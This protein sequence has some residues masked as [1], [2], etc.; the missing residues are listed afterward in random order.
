MKSSGPKP[1]RRQFLGGV[2]AGGVTLGLSGSAKAKAAA[3]A[4]PAQPRSVLP[5]PNLIAENETP[6]EE[7]KLTFG[8]A[9]SDFMTDV[10]KTLGIK[11]LPANPGSSF[12]GQQESI[13]NYGKNVDPEFLTCT[14]E[15][16]SVSM[17]HGY[18][19][20]AGK[21]LLVMV[22]G[23]VGLQHASMAIYNAF[24]DR[25]PVIML[26]GNGLDANTRRPGVEW[27]H[28]VEDAAVIVRDFTKYDDNPVSLQ[29]FAESMVRA[30]RVATAVP[31]A[32]VILSLDGDLQE[33]ELHPAEEAKL[34]IP[35]LTMDRPPS[36]DEG[37]LREL[38]KM[39]VAAENPLIIADAYAR[40]PQG[41]PMLIEL[42]ELLQ[43]PVADLGSRL[44]FP[45]THPLNQSGSRGSLVRKAD[46]VL[47]LEPRDVWAQ[48]NNL[49]DIPG[50]PWHHTFPKTAKMVTIST[51]R[52]LIRPNYQEMER[53]QSVDISITG[54]PEASMPALIEYVKAELSDERKR[55][56][57]E[58]GAKFVDAFH[59]ARKRRLAA[60]A[61]TWDLSPISPARVSLEL[62]DQIKGEDWA[63]VGGGRG[64]ADAL[65]EIDK[66]YQHMGGS[67]AAGVGYGGGA[68][69]GGA[70]AHRDEGRLAINHQNDG[71][72]MYGPGS[73]WTAAHHRI[74]MLTVMFNNRAYHQEVMHL[75]RIANRLGRS[76]DTYGVGTTITNPD[77]DFAKLAQS[78]GW[79]AQGPI[80]DPGDLRDAIKKALA[81]VKGGEP[82]LLDVIQQPRA[83]VLS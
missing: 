82:A 21:P 39:L 73:L 4:A 69:V 83:P 27:R 66:H 37:S 32:P 46:L 55:Q 54:D 51:Q 40:T 14:H 74:P 17:S 15:E 62:W 16:I 49:Q 77:I 13:V 34:V 22:H 1:D 43:A 30:Y 12:R 18:Y 29:H 56:L 41:M 45:N 35:E 47:M 50:R 52:L 78:M 42:A 3:D 79:Y 80:T 24:V 20:V 70:L 63:L 48:E 19:K 58:R 23:T 5:P 67:G 28:T 26:A 44:N 36:G 64:M 10:I 6:P 72:L 8:R 2:A 57:G 25:V 65:W 81:V 11:Y 33:E 7:P 71:D 31:M 76:P 68:A 9:G 61:N 75:Q 59:K 53:Y 38:A 60:V